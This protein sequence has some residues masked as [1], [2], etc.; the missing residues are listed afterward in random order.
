MSGQVRSGSPD[1]SLGRFR[2][3]QREPHNLMVLEV[4]EE[5][6]RTQVYYKGS[7]GPRL[8]K[9]TVNEKT[10]YSE[11]RTERERET[12]VTAGVSRRQ[13]SKLSIENNW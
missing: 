8:V 3:R 13:R 1:G 9:G 10:T 12:A 5:I 6:L 7:D 4:R 2:Q 11:E